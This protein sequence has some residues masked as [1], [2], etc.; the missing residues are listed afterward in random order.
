MI[1]TLYQPKVKQ[2]TWQKTERQIH[3]GYVLK[4]HACTSCPTPHLK[5]YDMTGGYS[6]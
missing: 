5:A 3:G 2:H 1:K 6:D 4:F